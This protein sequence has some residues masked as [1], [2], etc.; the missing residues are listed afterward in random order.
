MKKIILTISSLL[1]LFACNSEPTDLNEIKIE[2]NQKNPLTSETINQKIQSNLNN[3]GTFSWAENN[4][5]F[6]WSAIKIGNNL[7]TIGFGNNA[8]NF[9][10]ALTP[11]NQAIEQQILE[12][13]DWSAQLEER[14]KNFSKMFLKSD[15]LYVP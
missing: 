6:I 8:N 10:R 14:D 11:N 15:L 13:I 7:A 9:D 1:L 2:E 5:N 4:N 12:T 3:S